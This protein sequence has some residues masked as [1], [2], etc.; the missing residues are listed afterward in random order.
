MVGETVEQPRHG[1]DTD[2]I[3]WKKSPGGI[4]DLEKSSADLSL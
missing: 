3:G 1:K 2:P 4:Q